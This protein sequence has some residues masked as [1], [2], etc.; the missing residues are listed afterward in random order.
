MGVT[1]LWPDV[2]AAAFF[3]TGRAS[4]SSSSF[5]ALP[6]DDVPSGDLRVGR[7]RHNARSSF[8]GILQV[9]PNVTQLPPGQA[10]AQSASSPPASE[11]L[12]GTE[13]ADEASREEHDSAEQEE[14]DDRD[15]LPTH[16]GRGVVDNVEAGG[17]RPHKE[18]DILVDTGLMGRSTTNGD[19]Y[20]QLF[21]SGGR[22]GLIHLKRGFQAASRNEFSLFAYD[23]GRVEKIRLMADTDKKWFCDRVWLREP[24]GTVEFPVARWLGW[25][26]NPE[27]TVI[28][29]LASAGPLGAALAALITTVFPGLAPR[30]SE[31]KISATPC[32][33]Q[34]SRD[35]L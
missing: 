13:A 24:G 17:F 8:D 9:S 30:P 16:E 7:Q 21:G 31:S 22:T 28:P 32:K 25:P 1:A 15:D 4:C 12:P 26:E 14:V 10:P 34:N 5:H 35:F 18:Y 23:V 20:I 3:P 19:I 27:V 29:A 11:A 6:P 33:P 2:H